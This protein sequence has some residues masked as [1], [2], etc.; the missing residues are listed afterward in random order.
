MAKLLSQIKSELGDLSE[1]GVPLKNRMIVQPNFKLELGLAHH[2]TVHHGRPHECKRC[3]ML[4]DKGKEHGEVWKNSQRNEETDTNTVDAELDAIYDG[5]VVL[6]E[7]EHQSDE[8]KAHDLVLHADN[9]Y[10]LHRSSEV[11]IKKNLEKKHKKGIYDREKAKKLWGYHADRAA[12]SLHK[13]TGEGGKWHHHYPP[14]VRRLAA[15]HW[16]EH[17]HSEMADGHYHHLNEEVIVEVSEHDLLHRPDLHA[18]REH[19]KK[20]VEHS[21]IHGEL[22]ASALKQHGDHGSLISGV[23]RD[24]FPENTKTALRHHAHA[25]TQHI[26][27]GMKARPK[28]VRSTTMRKLGQVVAK[29]H[30][31]SGR[32]GFQSPR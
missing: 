10:Q 3:Q 9:D 30:G 20:S 27:A 6:N 5:D 31:P 16:E 18:A 11:P 7:E 12:Q 25:V 17:H 24:H 4:G 8:H 15:A 29:H 2:G 14:H 26:D 28:G 13:A 22:A 23:V 32:Y 21:R 19:F 1:G